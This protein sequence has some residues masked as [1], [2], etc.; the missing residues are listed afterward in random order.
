MLEGRERR[1]DGPAN[2]DRVFA[3][4]WSHNLDFH[5]L[6]RQSLDLFLHTF[7]N[8]S[9]HGGAAREDGVGVKILADIDVAL[10]DRIIR[11]LGNAVLLEPN[12]R[13]LEEDLGAAEP[14]VANGD[15]LTVWELVALFQLR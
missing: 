4:R 13:W 10:H 3:L 11:G 5:A 6:G 14:L 1:K 7:S 12:E 2:P 9:E 8:A 15:D